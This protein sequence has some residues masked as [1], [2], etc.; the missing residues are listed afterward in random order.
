MDPS[1]LERRIQT[2][3]LLA[4]SIVVVGG[5]LYW[6][7]PVMIP[8]VLAV[9]IALGIAPPVDVLV[10]RLRVPR[11]V[12]LL[13]TLLLAFVLLGLVAALVTSSVKQLTANADL[14]QQQLAELI[15]R[16]VTALPLA[17]LG[18]SRNDVLQQLSEI[19][20]GAVGGL[21]LG[22]TNAIM[23]TLSNAFLVLIFVIFLSIGGRGGAN[24]D[25][26]WR[27]IEVRIERY[28]A[29]KAVISAA[30]GVLVGTS[31]SL[32]GV[33]LALVFGLFAFL[34][35]FIPS[36]GS[37]VATLLPLPVVIVNPEI[38]SG[39]AA[40]AILVPGSLQFL[41]GSVLEPRIMGESLDLHPVT[42]LLALIVWGMLWGIVGMLLATPITAVMKILFEKLE[43]TRPIARLL[44]GRFEQG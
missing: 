1:Q 7:R 40:L 23:N 3:C 34:L 44:A 13:G 37:L 17:R 33:D 24:Q 41:I 26:T 12:A 4:I 21:L 42:I 38:S 16:V 15:D 20:V 29:T 14:Y 10:R 18:M 25:G 8:F 36:I 39:V 11:G 22:T 30:T 5:A 27:E 6:L 35:N 2:V 32:L 9:F 43:L 28:L 19:P 31:L